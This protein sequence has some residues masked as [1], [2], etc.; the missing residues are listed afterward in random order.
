MINKKYTLILTV[1]TF[2]L[3]FFISSAR[4]AVVTGAEQTDAYLK[5][6]KGKRVAFSPTNLEW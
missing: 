4:A 5:L 1:L 3:P 2:V 6:L